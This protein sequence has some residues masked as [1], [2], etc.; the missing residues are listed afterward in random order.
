MERTEVILVELVK[1]G[2]ED[3]K[4]HAERLLRPIIWLEWTRINENVAL[5]QQVTNCAVF[6]SFL[7][8]GRLFCRSERM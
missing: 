2:E 1:P 5:H 7:V 4:L 3:D 6:Y 8:L